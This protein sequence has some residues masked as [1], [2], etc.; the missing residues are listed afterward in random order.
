MMLPMKMAGTGKPMESQTQRTNSLEALNGDVTGVEIRQAP[1]RI[2][3][4]KAAGTHSIPRGLLK[5]TGENLIYYVAEIR[6]V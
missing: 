4:G 5:I 6:V 1:N 2:E 3:K